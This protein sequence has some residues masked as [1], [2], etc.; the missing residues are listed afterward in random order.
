[1]GDV[2][3]RIEGR[4]GRITM[5][6]PKALNA[7]NYDMTLAIDAALTDWAQDDRVALVLID[8]EGDKAFCAGGDIAEIHARGTRGD[9]S[10]ARDFWHD[11]Y[12]MN[13]RISEYPKPVVSFMQGFVMGGGVGLGCHAG[14]RIVGESSQIAMPECGIG[15]VPDVGGTYL[16]ARAP[17]QLGAYLGL[18]GARM[19]AGD[20]IRAGFADSYLPQA[21]WESTKAALVA[22]GDVGALKGGPVPEAPFA[23]HAAAIDHAFAPDNVSEIIAHL[24]QSD[25]EFGQKTLATLRRNSPL[26]MVCTLEL[27]RRQGRAG[28]IR[29]ALV[30]EYRATWRTLETGDFL[31]GIRAAIIDKD[32]SPRWQH[33][34]PEDVTREML[35]A[36][37]A[38]L[39]ANDLTFDGQEEA[40]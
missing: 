13:A 21:D 25:S 20:A 33:A 1:M 19:G 3:I 17:G 6:R 22:T 34:T 5:T 28:T 31:E 10:Y 7:L 24:A 18:T 12:R 9:Y 37:L 29:H 11:E 23:A 40:T 8:A 26:S 32:K 16:L 30:Q 4:A 15:L 27:L 14:H 35:E 36:M 38:P 2:H 39:G